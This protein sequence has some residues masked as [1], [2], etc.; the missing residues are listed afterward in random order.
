RSPAGPAH[1]L[2]RQRRCNA[3]PVATAECRRPLPTG[4]VKDPIMHSLHLPSSSRSMATAWNFPLGIEGF[5]YADLNRVRRLMALDQV[6]RAEL[7]AA[8]PDLADRFEAGGESP[9]A[10]L[11]IEVARHLDR[12]LGRLFHIQEEVDVLNRR[13]L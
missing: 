4:L 11:L 7:R 13:T 8:D 1:G 3:A 6:F 2:R 9:T 10:E 5:R 12:F